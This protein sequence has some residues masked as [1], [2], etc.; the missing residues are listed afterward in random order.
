MD[1][2]RDILDAQLVD[3]HGH[4]IGRVDG[5][6]LEL[7]AGRPPRVAAMELGMVTLARRLHPR[8][9]RWL[10]AIAA[11]ASPVAPRRVRIP[12]HMLRDIG[13][14]VELAVDADADPKFLRV[15]MWLGR[16]GLARVTVGAP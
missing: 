15:E 1:L 4:N 3:A 10:R 16:H 13:V 7:R 9:A 8:L 2:V 5:I 14:A 11:K 6:L 12:L